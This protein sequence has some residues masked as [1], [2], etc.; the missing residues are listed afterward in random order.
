[1]ARARK[2]SKTRSRSVALKVRH[3]VVS[4]KSDVFAR[5]S[6]AA[7][8]G[9]ETRRKKLASKPKGYAKRSAA[10]KKGWETR[11]LRAEGIQLSK[12]WIGRSSDG[13]YTGYEYERYSLPVLDAGIVQS[14]IEHTRRLHPNRRFLYNGA[15]D[16]LD[17]NDNPFTN[18]TEFFLDRDTG[19]Y[20][21][22]V[23]QI[24]K[25][26]INPS[27]PANFNRSDRVDVEG[28]FVVI[29]FERVNRTLVRKGI[30]G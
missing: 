7:K 10:A 22:L 11:R 21:K 2:Q 4:R 20:R 8:K 29:R 30:K 25:L 1:M 14:I 5:R 19:G 13:S 28:T 3:N 6:A 27:V 24:A 9:W 17:A 26:I 18:N 15:A 16:F 12:R 23:Q